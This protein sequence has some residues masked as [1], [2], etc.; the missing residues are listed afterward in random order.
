MY[1]SK[2]RLK[3][4]WLWAGNEL[5]VHFAYFTPLGKRISW[6]RKKR[7]VIKE[8]DNLNSIEKFHYF[9]LLAKYQKKSTS[10]PASS[11]QNVSINS[12]LANKVNPG[13]RH[14]DHCWWLP[15][16]EQIPNTDL[17]FPPNITLLCC[18]AHFFIFLGLVG[19][20]CSWICVCLDLYLTRVCVFPCRS[21]QR[22]R[23]AV[24]HWRPLVT[25]C[26]AFVCRG[27]KYPNTANNRKEMQQRIKSRGYYQSGFVFVENWTLNFSANEDQNRIEISWKRNFQTLCG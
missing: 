6:S 23:G 18:C 16:R 26:P 10:D 15:Y 20:L 22:G 8:F 1:F 5:N 21:L 14:W 24:V 17:A 11:S 2:F 7:I 9:Y 25:Y 27:E 4:K 3:E 13:R 19:L 12:W